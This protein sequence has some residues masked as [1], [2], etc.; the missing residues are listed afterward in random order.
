M[1]WV[2]VALPIQSSKPVLAAVQL[3]AG[4]L[5]F[6]EQTPS[7]NKRTCS[8]LFFNP[9]LTL[10]CMRIIKTEAFATRINDPAVVN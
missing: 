7:L 2:I 1:P 9:E 8:R 5:T 3:A 4:K 6:V 10:N